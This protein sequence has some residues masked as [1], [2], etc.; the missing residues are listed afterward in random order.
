MSNK[1]LSQQIQTLM[2]QFY[3][4][5]FD[6]VISKRKFIIKKKSRIRNSL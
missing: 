4:K 2:N 1:N 6:I 5:N 3:A